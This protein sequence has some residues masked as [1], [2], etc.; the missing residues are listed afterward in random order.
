MEGILNYTV[1][2]LTAINVLNE[3]EQIYTEVEINLLSRMLNET[4]DWKND[5]MK[6]QQALEPHQDNVMK[7]D[8]VKMKIGELNREVRRKLTIRIGDIS[9]LVHCGGRVV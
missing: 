3:D 8:D 4:M 2:L 5:T 1:H 9:T 7:P 6:K